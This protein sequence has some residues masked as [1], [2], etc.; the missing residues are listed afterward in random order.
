LSEE[1]VVAKIKREH[2]ISAIFKQMSEELFY[3]IILLRSTDYFKE[4]SP[5]S[6]VIIASSIEV[7]ELKYGEVLIH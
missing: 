7:K 2:F 6:L 4:L 3:K 5:Y 1:V